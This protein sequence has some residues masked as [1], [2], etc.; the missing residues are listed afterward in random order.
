MSEQWEANDTFARSLGLETR[1][2]AAIQ[3]LEMLW[4]AHD[5]PAHIVVADFNFEDHLIDACINGIDKGETYSDYPSGHPIYA[6]TREV[7]AWWRRN[8]TEEQRLAWLDTGA[9]Y[10]C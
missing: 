7:L 5:G 2:V 6:A 9:P 8:T 10:D 1:H 4:P 3:M